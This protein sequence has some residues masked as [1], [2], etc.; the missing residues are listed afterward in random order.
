MT[1]PHQDAADRVPAG[2][3]REV[4]EGEQARAPRR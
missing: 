4:V 3:G 1:R 2:T